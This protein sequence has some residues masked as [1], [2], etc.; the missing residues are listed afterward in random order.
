MNDAAQPPGLHLLDQVGA[1]T[2]RRAKVKRSA[3]AFSISA[4]VIVGG[5]GGTA[6]FW[7]SNAVP[8]VEATSAPAR[9]PATH[10]ADIA[11]PNRKGAE[12]Q[13]IPDRPSGAMVC[14]YSGLDGEHPGSLISRKGLSGQ[15]VDTLAKNLNAGR[16]AS[17]GAM[18]CPNDSGALDLITFAYPSGPTLAVLIRRSGCHLASNGSAVR[19]TTDTLEDQLGDG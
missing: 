6:H 14:R 3:I 8:A 5:I 17:T 1:K 19:W 10:P 16:R 2:R 15:T 9:C 11:K 4:V 7:R 18:S 13:L 12:K